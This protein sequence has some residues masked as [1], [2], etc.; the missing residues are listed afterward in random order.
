MQS[1]SDVMSAG[2]SVILLVLYS[3]TLLVESDTLLVN[4][5]M[6]AGILTND[7]DEWRCEDNNLLNDFLADFS[8]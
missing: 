8:R 6:F 5:T 3:R 4:T 1:N 2:E 7:G